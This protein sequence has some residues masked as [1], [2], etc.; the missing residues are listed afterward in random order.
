MNSNSNNRRYNKGVPKQSSLYNKLKLNSVSQEVVDIYG[1]IKQSVKRISRTKYMWV[2][3]VL[4]CI[5]IVIVLWGRAVSNI[6]IQN[7][8][9]NPILVP[10]PVNAANKELGAK[11]FKIPMPFQDLGFTYSFWI[12]IE[13]WS[14]KFG[15]WKNIIQNGD[16]TTGL[17]PNIGLYPRNNTLHARIATSAS[18]NEGCDVPNIPL[19][20]WVHIVY[21]LDN[22]NVNIYM[23]NKLEQSCALKGIPIVTQQSLKICDKGG[24]F[25]QISRVQYFSKTISPSKIKQLYYTGPFNSYKKYDVQLFNK[26]PFDVVEHDS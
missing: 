2:I 4:I 6:N 3:F 19:Q 1:T 11:N 20:K 23:N 15:H 21:V 13:D 17:S 8:R 9:F 7:N 26:T 10:A 25:G 18:P 14:Y 16:D 24:F 22:R 5:I 12:Y